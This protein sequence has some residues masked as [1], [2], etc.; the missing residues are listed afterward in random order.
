MSTR[1]H[2]LDSI[3]AALKDSPEAPVIPRGYRRSVPLTAGELIRILVDRLEDYK[4]G[5]TVVDTPEVPATL[6]RL[7]AGASSYVVPAGLDAAWLSWETQPARR[8]ADGGANGP[9]SVADLD[10]TDAVVTASAVTVAESGTIILD[11]SPD[12]GRRAISLIPDHHICIVRAAD[13]VAILPEALVRIDGTRPLTMISGPSATSDIE[14]ERVEGVHGP[15]RL[16]V[17][18][19]LDPA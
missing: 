2:I 6:E 5:V 9:L 16:D 18:V 12:Q 15:R 10:A 17:I 13:I 14:L 4:A 11:G 3:R 7:L 19:A 1:E 8:R